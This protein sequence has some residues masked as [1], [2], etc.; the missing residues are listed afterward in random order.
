M[1]EKNEDGRITIMDEYWLPVKKTQQRI[2]L[3]IISLG[4]LGIEVSAEYWSA[5]KPDSIVS[6]EPYSWPKKTT[7]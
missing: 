5:I 6:I 7:N 4:V 1:F 2:H 3:S